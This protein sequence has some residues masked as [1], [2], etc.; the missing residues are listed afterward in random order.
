MIDSAL[1]C[2]GCH[3]DKDLGS[4]AHPLLASAKPV[5]PPTLNMLSFL[6]CHRQTSSLFTA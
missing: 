5:W 1:A 2:M 3:Q 6:S 4:Q